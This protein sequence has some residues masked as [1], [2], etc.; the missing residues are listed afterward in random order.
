MQSLIK[1]LTF[2]VLFTA[3]SVQAHTGIDAGQH[4]DAFMQGLL[5]PLGG[6]DH[7]SAAIAVGLWGALFCQRAWTA[8][9]VFVLSMA[10]G[11]L[12]GWSGLQVD[13]VELFIASSVLVM[14]GLLLLGHIVS[15][16][17][18]LPLLCLLAIAHGLAHGHELSGTPNA[19]LTLGGLMAC[20]A[21]LHGLGIVAAQ[22]LLAQRVGLQRGV[23]MGLG[24]L[25]ATLMV[26]TSTGVA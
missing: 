3:T 15:T 19:L 26:I 4:H 9:T 20:T 2:G 25:G 14:G 24:L 21:L 22:R 12:L 1:W 23:G 13:G 6:I 7:I 8:P 11:A 5:H 16:R 17:M 18:A 10:F